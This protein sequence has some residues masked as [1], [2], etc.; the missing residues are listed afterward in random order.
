MKLK[1]KMD[2]L[3]DDRE[4]GENGSEESQNE[5]TKP[6]NG[7]SS[8]SDQKQQVMKPL[9]V[10]LI[11]KANKKEYRFTCSLDY[12]IGWVLVLIDEQG[13]EFERSYTLYK[14]RGG[15]PLSI[16]RILKMVKPYILNWHPITK[17]KELTVENE[18]TY[19]HKGVYKR[20]D[21]IEIQCYDKDQFSKGLYHAVEMLELDESDFLIWDGA[22]VPEYKSYKLPDRKRKH[23]QKYTTITS[24]R[25]SV[26]TPKSRHLKPIYNFGKLIIM[27]ENGTMKSPETC[28]KMAQK[29]KYSSETKAKFILKP[30]YQK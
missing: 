9:Y 25:R 20:G 5:T 3:G 14:N 21:C 2:D 12:F 23:M 29:F 4:G 13:L 17:E 1:D 26:I 15:K 6:K 22:Y 24:R 28:T 7:K 19:S 11:N 10:K 16:D 18:Y 8:Q 30:N 27:E